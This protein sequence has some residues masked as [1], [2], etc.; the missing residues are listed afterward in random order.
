MHYERHSDIDTI[1]RADGKSV[2]ETGQVSGILATSGEASDGHILNVA[3]G[4]TK[5]G[6]PLLFMHDTYD[7]N[8]GSWTGFE[9]DGEKLR[10]SAQIE[11]DGIG[12]KADWRKDTAHM[13]EKKHIRGF[14]LRWAETKPPIRRVDLSKDHPA[15]IDAEK[16]RD[17]SKLYGLYFEK[18]RMLEGSIV[19]LP[20]DTGALIG[21]MRDA[22]AGAREHWRK[23]LDRMAGIDAPTRPDGKDAFSREVLASFDH[24]DIDELEPIKLSDGRDFYVP[25]E[26][27]ELHS[28][29]EP[30]G[31]PVEKE[32]EAPLEVE[33][34]EALKQSE[35]ASASDLSRDDIF[36]LIKEVV[37]PVY[38]EMREEQRELLYHA[39]GVV[40]Q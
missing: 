8:L 26:L 18:W 10:G 4:T 39:L 17:F 30:I 40:K 15:F 24:I 22:K 19:T 33:V 34:A 12:A 29:R 35:D 20:S 23:V 31:A 25:R 3:G 9:N 36:Q 37:A 1:E 16:E 5:R 7:G 28:G 14:S 38:E 32:S 2:A 6:E 13:V 11:M 21:R 27:A